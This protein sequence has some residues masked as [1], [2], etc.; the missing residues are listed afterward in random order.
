MNPEAAILNAYGTAPGAGDGQVTISWQQ[1]VAG[2]SLSASSGVVVSGQPTAFT[3]TLSA[4]DTNSPLPTGSVTLVN[5]HKRGDSYVSDTLGQ[6]TLNGQSP[7]QAVFSVSQLPLGG[8]TIQADYSGDAFYPPAQT[9]ITATGVAPTPTPSPLPTPAPIPTP[10]PAPVPGAYSIM[11]ALTPAATH[12]GQREW[13]VKFK[14]TLPSHVVGVRYYRTAGETGAHVGRLWTSAG[15]LVATA[16][17]TTESSAGW[18]TAL[19]PSPVAIS[20]Q[21]TYT[22]SV[23]SNSEYAFTPSGLADGLGWSHLATIID[24]QNGVYS[25]TPGTFP[26]F[27]LGSANYFRDIVATTP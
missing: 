12:A 18:Q 15:Q 4:S 19:F 21:T 2:L 22:M 8:S 3:A 23:N 16:T 27:S 1:P 17:F 10:L 26:Q 5:I 11:S 20:A 25:F 6:A 14:A 7:D 13:G 9:E 24:G